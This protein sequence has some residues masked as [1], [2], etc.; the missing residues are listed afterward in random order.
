[1]KKYVLLGSECKWC[2]GEKPTKV[3]V[4]L[5][6][7]HAWV[8]R[9]IPAAKNWLYFQFTA[10]DVVTSHPNP[11]CARFDRALINATGQIQQVTC[12]I[13]KVSGIE[14]P[15]QSSPG[16]GTRLF[17]VWLLLSLFFWWIIKFLSAL[18]LNFKFLLA[19]KYVSSKNSTQNIRKTY[20]MYIYLVH[21]SLS[22]YQSIL[23]HTY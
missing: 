17:E 10:T 9:S 1:M 21:I 18:D 13:C 2:Q 6:R 20:I 12:I 16:C 7:H 23:T 15:H 14:K 3:R 22:I 19:L 5:T 11:G 8:T 4:D